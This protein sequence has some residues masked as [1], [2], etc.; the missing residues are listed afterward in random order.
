MDAVDREAAREAAL[1]GGGL[2]IM[3]MVSFEDEQ[4]STELTEPLATQAGL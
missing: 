1:R 2:K 4:L 3:T